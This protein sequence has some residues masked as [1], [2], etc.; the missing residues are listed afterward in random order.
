MIKIYSKDDTLR[1]TVDD[2]S[3]QQ[4]KGLQ[5]D[6]VLT[7]SFTLYEYVQLDVNDYVDFCGERF[8]LMERYKPK[9]KSTVEW[10]YDLEL[11]GVESLIKRF[12]VVN[13]TDGDNNP[14]FT[15]TAPAIEH[16]KLIVKS[17]NMAMGKELWT[18]G[19]VKATENL[20]IDYNGTYCNEALEM[21]GKAAGTEYWFEN[22]TTLNV[23]RAEYGEELRLGY[24]N[25]LISLEREKANN[26]KFYTRLFSLGSTRNIDPAKYGHARLQLP[27]GRTYVDKDVD[28]YGVIHHFEESAFAGIYP[29]RVGTVSAVRSEEKTGQDGKPFTIYYFKDDGLNFNPNDYEIAGYVKRVS[30]QEGSELAGQG[31]GADHYFEVNYN[32]GTKEFE[33]ITIFP[34]EGMQLPGGLLVPE[35]GDKYI[36][37]NLRMP[38]EYYPLAEQELLAAVE[39]YNEENFVDNSVYKGNTDYVFIEQNNVD[40][41]VGRRVRLESDK[42]FMPEGYRKSRITK[43]TRKVALPSQ[44]SLEISDAI[45]VGKIASM[46]GSITEVKQYVMQAT[47][48]GI[49]I[50][51]SGD[52]KK[53]GE[54]NVFS[55]K[56][57]IR[58]FVSRKKDDTVNGVITFLKGIV[59]KTMSYFKG[60]TNDGDIVNSGDINNK[61]DIVNGGD[62]H[63]R[64]LTVTGKATFFE[65]EIL[66][67]KAAGGLTINSPGTFHVDDCEET[68][69]GYKLY[70]RAEQDGVTLMQM[71][72][73]D[74]Q[75]FCAKFNIGE[76]KY[77]HAGNRYYWRRVIEVSEGTVDHI[78]KGETVKCLS[79]MLS[80][81]DCDK[82]STDTPKPGDDLMVLG[83]RTDPE[84]RGA[85]MTAAYR[86]FDGE[87]KAPYWAQYTGINSYDLSRHRRTY[88]ANN[89]SEIVG[90]LRAVSSTGTVVQVPADRGAWEPNTPYGYYDRVSYA[91]SL[92]LCIAEPGASTIEQPGTGDAWQRQVEKGEQGESAILLY[93]LADRGNIIRNGQGEVKLTA[94]LTQDGIDITEKYNDAA[95]SW[96]RT[97]GNKEYDTNWNARHAHVG[98]I[99]T[100]N[101]EDIWKRAVF[102]CIVES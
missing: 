72:A 8:W 5:S 7:L 13:Y 101:A 44:V 32:S 25:G 30:F 59:S 10:V 11:Y 78:I 66:K 19:E 29:R 16:A 35:V 50:I 55:A 81:T 92:W 9:M 90:S 53:P 88:L 77:T 6:N 60:I 56:R 102:D 41:F 43:I 36:L 38:D 48:G 89:K 21:L 46:E 82:A 1:C 33:I 58:E 12:L 37:S 51:G 70:Q 17:I 96:T 80:K 75:M 34:Y 3:G 93:I 45:S 62:I 20:V 83:N 64:N 54:H 86:S 28:K 79:I 40:L 85:T 18:V 22:G 27:G 84:R 97:S 76:G 42:Y 57:A 95:F 24:L 23:S 71:I 73:I 47:G 15:L 67:A 26:V 68:P 74:D 61:G 91:G 87:L 2:A 100:V 65:L 52:E 63:T 99:I 31:T 4:E 98:R 94:I 39:K 69:D 49:D 14:V